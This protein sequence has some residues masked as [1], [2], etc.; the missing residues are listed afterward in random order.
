MKG[1]HHHRSHIDHIECSH[2]SSM[3][4]AGKKAAT[5]TFAS[6]DVESVEVTELN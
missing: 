5:A 2:S 3:I 6:A 4:L 1:K